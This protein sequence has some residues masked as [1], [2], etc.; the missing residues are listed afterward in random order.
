M[1]IDVAP[2]TPSTTAASADTSAG[3]PPNIASNQL[4]VHDGAELPLNVYSILRLEA[5]ITW[6]LLCVQP[7]NC[8]A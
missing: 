4:G 3:Y 6:Q 5:C 1:P 7:P 8:Q 2:F